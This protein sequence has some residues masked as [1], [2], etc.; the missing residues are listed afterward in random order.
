MESESPPPAGRALHF[1]LHDSLALLFLGRRDSVYFK[2]SRDITERT[3]HLAW[4]SELLFVRS[5]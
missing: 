2:D 3:L 4:P 1:L 5:Y